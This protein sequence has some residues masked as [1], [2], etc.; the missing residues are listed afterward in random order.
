MKTH[1]YQIKALM[2]KGKEVEID[3]LIDQE[4]KLYIESDNRL[5]KAFATGDLKEDELR[6]LELKVLDQKNFLLELF[7]MQLGYNIRKRNG[8]N[9]WYQMATLIEEIEK[10]Y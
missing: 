5:S 4:I 2:N 1:K 7:L 9:Q 3:A 8:Y 10:Q 6:E